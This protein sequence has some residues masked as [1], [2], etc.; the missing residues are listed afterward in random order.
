[1]GSITSSAEKSEVISR[2]KI[3]RPVVLGSIEL[4][5]TYDSSGLLSPAGRLLRLK[6]SV[7]RI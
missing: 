4:I 5:P 7:R 6:R 1:M 2:G 3:I